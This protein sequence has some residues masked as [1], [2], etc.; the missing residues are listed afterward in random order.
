MLLSTLPATTKFAFLQRT[1]HYS[2]TVLPGPLLFWPCQLLAGDTWQAHPPLYSSFH[3]VYEMG[4]GTQE[5]LTW[6]PGHVV[7][8]L[9]DGL[10]HT[11]PELR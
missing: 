8:Q 7:P 4:T 2:W 6:L 11:H 1:P 5:T 9:L 3:F 10:V